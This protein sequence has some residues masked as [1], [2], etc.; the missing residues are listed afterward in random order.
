MRADVYLFNSGNAKSRQNAKVLIEAGNVLID[1]K[2]ITK[3][4]FEIDELEEHDVEIISKS[5]FV[6]RGGEKLD[7]AFDIFNVDVSNRICIDIGASTGGFTDCLLQRGADRVY[8]VDSGHSQLDPRIENDDRVISIEKYN[9]KFMTSDDFDVRFDIAVMDVSFISQT[10]IHSGVAEVLKD[11]GIFIS[12]IKPQFECGKSALN[13]HGIVKKVSYHQD[14]ICR[15]I[16]SAVISGFS[17]LDIVRS[18]IEGGSG[19]VE[20][21]AYFKKSPHPQNLVSEN[22]IKVI[23]QAK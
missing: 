22:K 18:P 14:A 6:S 1:S 21:L 7:F 10:L 3:P 20:F 4:A 9:A 12:L 23:L 11:E 15:V 17:C 8:A 13:S 5:K 19:N 2:K 16:D